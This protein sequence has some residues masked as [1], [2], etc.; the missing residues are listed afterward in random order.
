MNM[1]PVY[2]SPPQIPYE[3]FVMGDFPWLSLIFQTRFWFFKR[4]R[5]LPRDLLPMRRE[6][7]NPHVYFCLDWQASLDHQRV[8]QVLG[9]ALGRHESKQS[10]KY[11]REYEDDT[12]EGN[13]TSTN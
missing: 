13:Q 3:N 2:Y 8:W 12:Q 4:A 11:N 10:N 1:I 6:A 9:G 7:Y 5:I